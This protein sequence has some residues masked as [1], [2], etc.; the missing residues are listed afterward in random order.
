MIHRKKGTM[1][2]EEKMYIY[3]RVSLFASIIV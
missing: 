3:I 2:L 1:Y